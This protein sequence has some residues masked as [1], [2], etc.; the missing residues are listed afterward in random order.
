M[1]SRCAS[2][3]VQPLAHNERPRGTAVVNE[4]GGDPSEATGGRSLPAPSPRF[5]PPLLPLLQL[6]PKPTKPLGVIV[7]FKEGVV[8]IAAAGTGTARRIN[9]ELNLYQ[10]SIKD[11]ASAKDKAADLR[12]LSGERQQGSA[13]GCGAMLR[14]WCRPGAAAEAVHLGR[15]VRMAAGGSRLSF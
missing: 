1:P 3:A 14:W 7:K 9:A 5:P 10:L 8:G 13:K 11:G 4:A 6:G 15:Q 12:K 2:N